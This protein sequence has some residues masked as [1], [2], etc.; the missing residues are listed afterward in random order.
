MAGKFGQKQAEQRE[1]E[2]NAGR[3]WKPKEGWND[4][5]IMPPPDGKSDISASNWFHFGEVNGQRTGWVCPRRD[6]FGPKKDAPDEY[7]DYADQM[8]Q[9]RSTL[10]KDSKEWK[11]TD[12]AVR[13]YGAQYRTFF[14][15]VDMKQPSLGPRPW[16]VSGKRMPK[17][18]YGCCYDD[19]GEW[20]DITDA[21]SGRDVLIQRVGTGFN[22]TEYPTVRAAE[23]ATRLAD[24]VWLENYPDVY[25]LARGGMPEAPTA[26]DE[27]HVEV[28]DEQAADPQPPKR[29]ATAAA[30]GRPAALVKPTF[31]KK[32][33]APAA[34]SPAPP[35]RPVAPAR[36]GAPVAP[37]AVSTARPGRPA[38][39][40]AAAPARSAPGRPAAP[41]AARPAAAP[42][43]YAGKGA[44]PAPAAETN[45]DIPEM[46]DFTPPGC[47]GLAAEHDPNDPICQGCPVEAWCVVNLDQP[48][49]HESFKSF[50]E[51]LAL[52]AS[53]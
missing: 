52:V 38:V 20:R 43:T 13:D 36:P 47:F 51:C 11:E 5:R 46:P 24:P 4:I 44:K 31:G 1:G 8:R 41:Q 49:G 45:G 9:H 16:A 17:K 23:Q 37:P 40:T 19:Q 6:V 48:Q 28:E 14:A 35:A 18:I 50:D 25:D 7:C 12:K 21:D 26:D 33:G 39:P 3:W 34:A 42:P 53:A 27:T 30:P 15:I 10:I 32:P 22:D 2:L 29:P